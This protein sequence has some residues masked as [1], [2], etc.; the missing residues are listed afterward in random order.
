MRVLIDMDDTM[1]G[2]L[3]VWLESLNKKHGT[4]V[5]VEDVDCWDISV[6]FPGLTREEVFAPLF[7]EELWMKVKPV[8]G[9]VEYVKRIMDDGHDVYVVTASHPQ[10]V[11]YKVKHVIERC[12]PYISLD[13]IIITAHKELIKGDVLIDDCPENLV[14]WKYVGILMDMPHN[15]DFDETKFGVVRAKDWE[16]IYKDVCLFADIL[17]KEDI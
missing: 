13:K 17:N 1:E 2:L 16:S 15:R 5:T 3:P 6:K 9:A 14:M 7:S 4:N 8:D 12:F 10:T 11:G